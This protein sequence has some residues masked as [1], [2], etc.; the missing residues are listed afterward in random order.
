[1]QRR[2]FIAF[3]GGS[4]LSCLARPLRASAQTTS[5]LY[6]LRPVPPRDPLGEKSRSGSILVRVLAERG[7]VLGQ[8]LALDA[9]GAK[10]D[11]RLLPQILNDMKAGNVDAFVVTGFPV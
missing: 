8:N 2:R 7:Y 10:G 6:R 5:K 1:M 4:A 11:M 3:V 9:R